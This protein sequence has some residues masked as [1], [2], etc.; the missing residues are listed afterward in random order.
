MNKFVPYILV[1]FGIM[2]SSQ[3]NSQDTSTTTKTTGKLIEFLSAESYNIKKI[4]SQD[5]LVLVGHVKIKQG[6]TF[7]Y[8]DSIIVNT[9]KNSLEGF[10]KVHINDADSVHTYA[11]YLIYDG[12]TKKAKL[13]KH[14]KLTDGRG[15]LTTDSLD[16]DV[17]IKIGVYKKGGK[18]VRNK[19]VLKSIEG[20]Y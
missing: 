14:V 11:D 3:A 2:L 13:R 17:S 6:N 10:G 18:L 7:L 19:T 9:S 16:Y 4:D 20:V 5:F 15:T 1:C 12:N 8:G